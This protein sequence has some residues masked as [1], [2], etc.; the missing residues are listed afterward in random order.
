MMKERNPQSPIFK[1]GILSIS[2]LLMVAPSIAPAVPLMMQTFSTQ[3]TSAVETLSTIPNLGIILGIFLSSWVALKIGEKK[4]V[5]TGLTLALI[6]GFIPA[7][8]SNYTVVLTMRF[9]FGIGIGLFNSLAIS[10]IAQYYTGD[11][12]S[13]MMGFQNAINALGATLLAFAVGFLVTF[14]WHETFLIYL[15]IIPIMLIFALVVPDKKQISVQADKRP[16]TKQHVNG[17]VIGISILTFFIYVFFMVVTVKLSNLL[18]VTK[19]GTASQAATILGTFT[20][21]TMLVGLIYGRVYKLLK[22]HILP[23]G[24]LIIALG[25][26]LGGTAQTLTAIIIGVLIIGLGF[27]LSIPYIYTIVNVKAPKGS[28]NLASALVL[29]MTNIGVFISPI[30]IDFISKLFGSTEPTVNM[31]VS[32]GGFLILFIVSLLMNLI[33]KDQV[34]QED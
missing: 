24:F 33:V 21:V 3:S 23:L 22:R 11:E 2:M 5:M 7:L 12:L 18:I 9:L 13:T 32:A 17:A 10:L 27:G 28:E 25:F 6:S 20:L 4:T 1:M 31:L 19:L 14:G 26:L 8:S 30:M 29:V 15:I 16:T 34:K